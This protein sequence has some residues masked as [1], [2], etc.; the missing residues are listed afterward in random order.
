LALDPH[1]VDVDIRVE[2]HALPLQGPVYV[3]GIRTASAE[4]IQGSEDTLEVGKDTWDTP[5]CEAVAFHKEEPLRSL[6]EEG[7]GEGHCHHLVAGKL[8][9]RDRLPGEDTSERW[10]EVLE[11]VG[12]RWV[13]VDGAVAVDE[14]VVVVA[15]DA[16]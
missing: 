10:D 7:T 13:A 1:V 3:E 11:A 16:R 12:L 4:D 15:A 8:G 9:D 14:A 5:A 6:S 2:E